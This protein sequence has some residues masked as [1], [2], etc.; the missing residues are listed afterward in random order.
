MCACV[1][2][3]FSSFNLM[4]GGDERKDKVDH[5]G[6]YLIFLCSGICVALACCATANNHT[7]GAPGW[8]ATAN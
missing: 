3:F 8:C 1:R 4:C 7:S 6:S 5:V 2:V